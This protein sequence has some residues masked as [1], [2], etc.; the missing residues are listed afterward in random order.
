MKKMILFM[1]IAGSFGL[2]AA[3]NNQKTLKGTT[4]VLYGTSGLFGLGSLYNI[5]RLLTGPSQK[6]KKI[7]FYRFFWKE[8]ESFCV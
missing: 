5:G 1:L 8:N 6:L 3:G 4:N 2:I 7:Q